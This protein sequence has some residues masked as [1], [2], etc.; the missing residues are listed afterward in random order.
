MTNISYESIQWLGPWSNRI[1]F[2]SKASIITFPLITGSV[3]SVLRGHADEVLES[4]V[5]NY[6]WVRNVIRDDT[7]RKAISENPPPHLLTLDLFICGIWE[8]HQSRWLCLQNVPL[9]LFGPKKESSSFNRSHCFLMVGNRDK[10]DGGHTWAQ[11]RHASIHQL[12][13]QNV[14]ISAFTLRGREGRKGTLR[15]PL[16]SGTSSNHFIQIGLVLYPSPINGIYL[17]SEKAD[18]GMRQH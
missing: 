7:I 13:A 1:T 10:R 4:L 3:N 6:L 8:D 2:S 15:L 11:S 17:L 5:E 18:N 14:L 9:L 16:A 12:A